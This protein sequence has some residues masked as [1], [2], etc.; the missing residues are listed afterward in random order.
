MGTF[1]KIIS[2]FFKTIIYETKN[3]FLFTSNIC[4]NWVSLLENIAWIQW[5]AYLA[6]RGGPFL[7]LWCKTGSKALKKRKKQKIRKINMS[8]T[9]IIYSDSFSVVLSFC[10]ISIYIKNI[11]QMYFPLTSVNT[12]K[13]DDPSL[14]FNSV[15]TNSSLW[16]SL[17]HSSYSAAS[18]TRLLWRDLMFPLSK[19]SFP[20]WF[21][22]HLFQNHLCKGKS[23]YLANTN[24]VLSVCQTV[25]EVPNPRLH[26]TNTLGTR[27]LI[28]RKLAKYGFCQLW[29]TAV[30]GNEEEEVGQDGEGLWECHRVKQGCQRGPLRPSEQWSEFWGAGQWVT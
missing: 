9:Y 22:F 13:E 8:S 7:D 29:L 26:A 14:L 20:L 27:L 16:L 3:L 1:C 25:L 23:D 28:T 21:I 10:F 2:T 30:E 17:R 12:H 15:P 18:Y 6:W 11:L 4:A 5:I 24:R 19:L